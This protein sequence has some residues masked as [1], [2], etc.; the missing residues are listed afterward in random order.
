MGRSYPY[1]VG[2]GWARWPV[3]RRRLSTEEMNQ[4][5][6]I[7]QFMRPAQLIVD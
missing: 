4:G 2:R 1:P 5:F 7:D 6:A 3:P